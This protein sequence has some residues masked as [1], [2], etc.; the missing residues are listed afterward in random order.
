MRKERSQS[1]EGVKAF[2]I[3]LFIPLAFAAHI[4]FGMIHGSS[5]QWP[6]VELICI[7]AALVV[8]FR[9]WRKARG[10]RRWIVIMNFFGWFFASAFLWWTQI[11]SSYP[12]VSPKLKVGEYLSGFPHVAQHQV[13]KPAAEHDIKKT[14]NPLPEK[15]RRNANEDE[16]VFLDASGNSFELIPSSTA[17]EHIP[18]TKTASPIS[19]PVADQASQLSPK[20]SSKAT[21]YVFLRGWW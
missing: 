9:M 1:G 5:Q 7:C 17:P 21:L 8:L 18:A 19:I 11:Y 2:F 16:E 14:K 4:L 3:F 20:S 6:V 12:P 15:F 10:S 13:I